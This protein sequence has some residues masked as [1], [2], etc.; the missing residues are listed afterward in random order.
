MSQMPKVCSSFEVL[1]LFSIFSGKHLKLFVSSGTFS[2]NIDGSCQVLAEEIVEINEIDESVSH[3]K[4]I[5]DR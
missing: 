2:M 3:F 5:V 4:P 1:G